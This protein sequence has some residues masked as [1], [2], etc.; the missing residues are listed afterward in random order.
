MP[1][2]IDNDI[3]DIMEYI[4]DYPNDVWLFLGYDENENIGCITVSGDY[5]PP[6][7]DMMP[8]YDF[9]TANPHVV[10]LKNTYSNGY[11]SVSLSLTGMWIL[12]YQKRNI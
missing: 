7:D 8:F 4:K 3:I 6:L 12:Y 2:N 11:K 10:C 5:D 9:A 1:M